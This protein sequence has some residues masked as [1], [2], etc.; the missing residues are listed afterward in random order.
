MTAAAKKLFMT[1]PSV[2]QA[3]KELEEHYHAVLFERFPKKLEPTASGDLLFN[4]ATKILDTNAELEDLMMQGSSKHVLRIGANDTVGSSI[5][6]AI[7][8]KYNE[9]HPAEH[10]QIFINRSSALQDMLRNNDLDLAISDEFPLAQDL[11]NEEIRKD[12]FLLVASSNYP[13][14]PSGKIADPDYLS[15]AR[16]LLREPGIDERDSFDRYMRK[17][18]HAIIPFWESI[19]FDILLSATLRG[20][21]ISILPRYIVEAHL[22]EGRL[23]ELTIPDYDAKQTFVLS[24]QKNKYLTEDMIDFIELCRG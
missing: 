19:S 5:L 24:Y 4:Y 3:I 13:D 12:D 6:D 22:K 10:V 16:L 17:H 11:Y 14:L 2:S 20:T 21:G 7:V 23:T 18:G 1:Q 15:R 8:R 9:S